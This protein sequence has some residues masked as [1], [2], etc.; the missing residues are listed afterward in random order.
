MIEQ[1]EKSASAGAPASPN[2]PIVRPI[3]A[4]DINDA[5]AKGI[6]D[7]RAAPAYG[8]M[9]GAFYAAGGIV[10]LFALAALDFWH[11]AYPLAAALAFIG[12]FAAIG[13][14][15]VSR[16]REAGLS[17]SWHTL[18]AAVCNQRNLGLAWMGLV[19]VFFVVVWIYLV[20]L[21]VPLFLGRSAFGSLDDF[22]VALTMTSA[23]LMFLF[24][25]NAIGVL[26]SIALFSITFVSFPL[27]LDRH[28]NF[29][30][31][32]I[33]SLRAVLISPLAAIGWAVITVLLLV[34]AC[35]PVFLGLL[36]VLPVLGHTT[37]HLYRK[38]VV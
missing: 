35:L 31:G 12:P 4:A 18:F 24:L 30:T 27:L 37:W 25:S 23:G 1:S 29:L 3:R 10:V 38:I 9:F 21:L 17:L 5:W 28:V 6:E 8:L 33:T 15:E 2:D 26:L 14:Y 22:L 11:L 20:Q 7:F 34:V 13:L 36:V 19:T 32:I 16:R